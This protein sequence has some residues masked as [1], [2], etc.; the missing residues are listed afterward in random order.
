MQLNLPLSRRR[1][2]RAFPAG[3]P[4]VAIV[5]AGFAGVAAAVELKRAGIDT[6]TV[7]EMSP[8]VGG[9]WWDSRFPGAACDVE[10]HLYSF[11]FALHDWQSSHASQ[12]EIQSYLESV[13]DRFAVRPN[14]RFETKVL[15]AAWNEGSH[16]YTLTLASGEE[17]RFDVVVGALGMLNHP[18]YPDWPG[19]EDFR[20]PAFH[21]SR[22][23][24]EH[25]LAGKTVAVV[26]TG[27]SAAQVVPGLAPTVGRLLLFQR[28]APWV[29]PK[30]TGPFT[31]EELAR[32]RRPFAKRLKRWKIFLTT[33]ARIRGVKVGSRPHRKAEAA[34]LAN[35][36][37]QVEDPALR[38]ALRP[39]YPFRCKRPVRSSD[40]YPAMNRPNVELVPRA[41]SSVTPRGL[42]DED[43]VEHEVD[44]I[45]MATG[46]QT[47]NILATLEVVGKAGRTIHQA[48]NG[49]PEAFLGIGYPGFPNFFMLYGPNTNP[50][51]SSVVFQLEAQASYIARAVR[52]MWRKGATVAEVRPR[53]MAIYQQWVEK[54]LEGT[55]Y[56]A[57]CSSYYRAPTGKIVTNWPRTQILYWALTKT[58]MRAGTSFRRGPRPTAPTTAATSEPVRRDA[59]Q[60][61]VGDPV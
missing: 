18:K 27:S 55:V 11:S 54:S 53:A 5:G 15:A 46:F 9:T 37:A 10:S 24:P 25:D 2:G 26:G 16:D 14:F 31:G 4:I 50:S 28:S 20:G 42:V 30:P 6:F 47:A 12:P 43:G 58:L 7:F 19:L 33:E 21:T 41:V 1:K 8:G 34:L 45:V 39:T 22:W 17:L 32:F 59:Q 23:E 57:G 29:V 60:E 13:I 49:E 48:W 40:F 35:L 36:E 56:E 52:R 51:T 61:V 3:T 44:V 38:E